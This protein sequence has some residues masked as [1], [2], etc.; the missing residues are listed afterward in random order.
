MNDKYL[1]FTSRSSIHVS[2][3]SISSLFH[4]NFL[5]A[6]FSPLDRYTPSL[7]PHP[8]SPCSI[9][10]GT[11]PADTNLPAEYDSDEN[12]NPSPTTASPVRPHNTAYWP[13]YRAHTYRPIATMRWPCPT[14]MTKRIPFQWDHAIALHPSALRIYR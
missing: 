9:R 1:A 10:M 13:E 8:R 2:L 6:A 7:A 5:A 3:L 12:E 14:P 11:T 4:V